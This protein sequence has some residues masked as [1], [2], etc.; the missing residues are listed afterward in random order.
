L[1]GS[2]YGGDKFGSAAGLKRDGGCSYG[3]PGQA[4]PACATQARHMTRPLLSILS[5]ASLAL[6]SS[7]GGGGSPA[8]PTPTPTAIT[9]VLTVSV[10]SAF[11]TRE[12]GGVKLHVSLRYVET[13]GASTTL[14][15]VDFTVK[16]NGVV[17]TTYES[18]E[19]HVIG[20]RGS[21]DI[22]YTSDATN[23]PYPTSVDVTATYTDSA[24]V[25][26]S[27]T[28]TGTFVALPPA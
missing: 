14:T 5:V 22:D 23:D 18:T 26:R 8:G 4:R 2:G 19:S 15:K 13:A 17:G 7:C 20:A 11:G 12:T 6:L 21:L 28:A 1:D 9:G 24:G 3:V 16:Q 25:V 27:A 10:L